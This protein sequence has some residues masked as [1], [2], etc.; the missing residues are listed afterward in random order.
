MEELLKRAEGRTKKAHAV[1]VVLV[2]ALAIFAGIY[3]FI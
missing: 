3:P 2:I 1:V